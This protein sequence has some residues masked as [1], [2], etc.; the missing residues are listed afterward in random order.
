VSGDLGDLRRSYERNALDETAAPHDPFAQFG[1]WFAEALA[2]QV[3]E[4][5]AMTLATADAAGNPAARIVLLR[6]WD[7][8]G[9]VFFTNYE[10]RKGRDLA[11]R[12]RAALVWYW[13]ALERQIRVTGR[14]ERLDPEASDAYFA[15]RPRGHRLSAWAS[16]QS[17]R[18][19]SRAIL[20]QAMAEA[21]TRFA[22]V[23]VPRP[24][25][26]GGYRVIPD[27]FEFWQGRPNRVH[28]RL[29]YERTTD[30]WRRYRLAP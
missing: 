19:E 4:P 30:G 12:P 25:W 17:T 15:R 7:V 26:W 27:A 28:D 10:S 21:D 3:A 5:H 14:V 13:D 2:A 11:T 18:V 1:T 29:A 8:A 23:D 22:G 9:F 24:A 16:P 20:E 6:G